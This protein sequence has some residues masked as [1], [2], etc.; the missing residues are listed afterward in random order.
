VNIRLNEPWMPLHADVTEI[1]RAIAVDV[2]DARRRNKRVAGNPAH[3]LREV[4]VFAGIQIRTSAGPAA[5]AAGA[6]DEIVEA[7]AVRRPLGPI[8]PSPRFHR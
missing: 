1:D 5:R 3:Y 2:A 4:T 7:V 8:D 6:D